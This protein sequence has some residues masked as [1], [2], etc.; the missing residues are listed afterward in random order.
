MFFARIEQDGSSPDPERDRV[1]LE[2]VR[3]AIVG[4][5]GLVLVVGAIVMFSIEKTGVGHTL[6]HFAEIVIVGGLGIAIGEQR[7]ARSATG[8]PPG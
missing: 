5:I 6:L 3:L 1:R 8:A 2:I 7:G 4:L